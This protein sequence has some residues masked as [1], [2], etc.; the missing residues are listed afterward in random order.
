[1]IPALLVDLA[2][3]LCLLFT[4]FVTFADVYALI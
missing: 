4:R 1:M 2:L 3:A